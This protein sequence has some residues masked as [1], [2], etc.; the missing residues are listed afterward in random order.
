MGILF[1]GAGTFGL[2]FEYSDDDVT[3]TAIDS[4]SLIAADSQWFW[5]DLSGAPSALY[6]RVRSVSTLD[7]LSV[8]EL[9]FGNTPQEIVL[10]PWNIDDY[11]AMPNK[12]QG[13]QVLNWY[14]QRDRDAPYLLVWPVPNDLAKYDLLVMWTHEMLND[15]TEVTQSL[16]VPRRWYDAITAMLARRLCRS[17]EEGDMARYQMA[18]EFIAQ[19]QRPLQIDARSVPPSAD[20]G[21]RKRFGGGVGG[22]PDAAIFIAGIDDGEADAGTGDRGALSQLKARVARIDGDAR[23][24]IGAW[25]HRSHFA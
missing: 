9:Y 10:G 11:T 14:Q 23:Q 15:V 5:Y 16:D 19:F 1:G 8:R 18:A 17:L 4:T 7:Q 20:G 3:Y 22:E 21:D 24:I 13:G 25:M 6:W 2:F 12:T